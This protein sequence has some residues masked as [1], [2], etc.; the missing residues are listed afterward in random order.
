VIRIRTATLATCLAAVLTVLAVGTPNAGAQSTQPHPAG[1]F[2]TA[3]VKDFPPANP[4]RQGTPFAIP[5]MSKHTKKVFAMYFTALPLSYDN[6]APAQDQYACYTSPLCQTAYA[7]FGGV[8]R[9]RPIP[10]DPLSGDWS[11]ADSKTEI[12]QARGAGLDGFTLDLLSLNNHNDRDGNYQRLHTMFKAAPLVDKNFKIMLMPDTDSYGLSA[13]QMAAELAAFTSYSAVYRVKV[14]GKSKV[15]IAPFSADSKTPKYWTDVLAAL[16]ARRPAVDAVLL[17]ILN[18][19][20]NKNLE[21]FA[22]V[23]WGVSEW[24]VHDPIQVSGRSQF[25]VRAHQAKKKWMQPIRV[26]DARPRDAVFDEAG[27]GELLRASWSAANSVKADL[28]LLV[29]WSD[30]YETT[31]FAPSVQHGWAVLDANAYMQSRF[32]TG[33]YPTINRDAVFISHR[34]QSYALKPTTPGYVPMTL[35]GMKEGWPSSFMPARDTVEV[36]TMLTKDAQVRVV[37]GGKLITFTA[38]RGTHTRTLPLAAGRVSAAIYRMNSTTKKY[39]LLGT[40][41]T[42]DAVVTTSSVQDLGYRFASSLRTL[43]RQH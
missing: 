11:L 32:Q 29:S 7:R 12:A 38:K 36:W 42:P 21:S 8:M 41:A 26:Q 34:V 40:V 43:P 39:S 13:T 24:G 33:K 14:A 9:D 2:S 27:N 18:V 6:K 17:P 35:R 30:Y 3:V 31:A 20:T 10:R 19:D 23:S 22:K 28:A 15:V 4:T 5:A 1:D 16:K 37:I 25:A